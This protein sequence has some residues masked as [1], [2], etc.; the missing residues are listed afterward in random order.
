MRVCLASLMFICA[1]QLSKAQLIAP[2]IKHL[3][4][5]VKSK[6]YVVLDDNYP[7][8]NTAVKKSLNYWKATR[9]GYEF[10]NLS[11]FPGLINNAKASFLVIQDTVIKENNFETKY[12]VL[13]VLMGIRSRRE[14]QLPVLVSFPI[15]YKG[16]EEKMYYRMLTFVQFLQHHLEFIEKYESIPPKEIFNYYN[17]RT[18]NIP[19]KELWLLK[20]DLAEEINNIAKIKMNYPFEVVIVTPEQLQMGIEKQY[21]DIAFL[22]KVGPGDNKEG[23][24]VIK[25]I[26]STDGELYYFD[27]Y[28]ISAKLPEGLSIRDLK[29]FT[30]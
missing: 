2:D 11:E 15:S 8:Y 20:E 23:K 9:L 27:Q 3:R 1:L 30:K 22:H 14:T 25:Y 26:F 7:G 17:S 5:F 13:K 6:L 10:I 12:V 24:S 29:R 16:Q 18:H 28:D 19:D 4:A 21:L